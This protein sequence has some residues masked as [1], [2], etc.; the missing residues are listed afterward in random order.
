[1]DSVKDFSAIEITNKLLSKT[2]D[3][4]NDYQESLQAYNDDILKVVKCKSY[5]YITSIEVDVNEIKLHIKCEMYLTYYNDN[6]SLC[7]CDFEEEYTKT[8]SVD[9]LSVNAF[10]NAQIVDKYTNYR[11]INQRRIDIHSSSVISLEIYDKAKI[12]MLSDFQGAK[13]KTDS[14]V[15]SEIK[16]C[17]ISKLEFDE[18]F[19]ANHSEA[20]IKRIISSSSYAYISDLKVIKDKVFVKAGVNLCVLY[21]TDTQN[22]E[23]I[24]DEYSFNASK[25]IDI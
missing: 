3:I 24:K 20:S 12:G 23:I 22:E 10:V 11:V 2:I 1:M 7:Y 5:N 16:S 6:S 9:N 25:I 15:S 13:L 14:V 18:E 17:I 4:E 19:S 21:T 8:V